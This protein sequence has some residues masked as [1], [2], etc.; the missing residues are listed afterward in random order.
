MSN[1]ELDYEPAVAGHLSDDVGEG[2]GRRLRFGVLVSNMC[3]ILAGVGG[4]GQGG[5]GGEG[6]IYAATGKKARA[7]CHLG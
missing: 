6:R 3:S 2:C 1:E 5:D 4:L 7:K